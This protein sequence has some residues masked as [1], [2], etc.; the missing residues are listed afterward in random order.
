M[1]T[2]RW[3]QVLDV[4]CYFDDNCENITLTLCT[5]ETNLSDPTTI[6]MHIQVM[7]LD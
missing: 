7:Y 6:D 4:N 2:C 1:V 3:S 5:S